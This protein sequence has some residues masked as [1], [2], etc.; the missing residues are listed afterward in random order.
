VG[1][2]ALLLGVRDYEDRAFHSL[3]AVAAD[4]DCLSQVLEEPD[5]GGFEITAERDPDAAAM[6]A[7]IAGFLD[8]RTPDDVVVL[9]LSGHG[10]WSAGIGQLY[11]AARDTRLDLLVQTGVPAEYLNSALEE[12]RAQQKAVLLDCCYSGAFAQGFRTRGAGNRT[13]LPPALKSAVESRGVYVITAC[14]QRQNAYEGFSG[15]GDVQPSLFTAAV[16]NGLQTGHADVMGNGSITPENL[17]TYVDEQFRAHSDVDQSPTKS[18]VGVVGS[19]M[20]LA[21][22]GHPL[23]LRPLAAPDG[24]DGWARTSTRPGDEIRPEAT[25]TRLDR[26]SWRRLLDYYRDCLGLEAAN[27]ELLPLGAAGR[28][29][30]ALWTGADEIMVGGRASVPVPR[31]TAAEALVRQAQSKGRTL[32][33]GYPSVLLFSRQGDRTGHLAPLFTRIVEPLRNGDGWHLQPVGVVM[34]H[35]RLIRQ[36]LAADDADAVLAEFEPGW[37]AGS[38]SQM[39]REATKRLRELDLPTEPLRPTEL[40]S[41]LDDQHPRSGGCN[42][43]LLYEAPESTAMAQGIVDGLRELREKTATFA[44]TGL[45]VFAADSRDSTPG[46]SKQASLRDAASGADPV[47]VAPLQLNEAQEAVLRSA[48]TRKLTVATGPPGTGKSQLVANLIATAVANDQSVLV[49]STNNRAVDEV[50]ERCQEI[51]PGLILRTGS[52]DYVQ[53]EIDCLRSL[54]ATR[55]SGARPDWDRLRLRHQDH[56]ETCNRCAHK[57]RTEAE[58]HELSL[59]RHAVAASLGFDLADLPDWLAQDSKVERQQRRA[60]AIAEATMFGDWQRRRLATR[61]D[62]SDATRE[63]CSR[64]A[65][66]LKIE[67]RWRRLRADADLLPSDLTLADELR[68]SQTEIRGA[69][70]ALVEA[71]VA[72]KVRR[73]QDGIAQRLQAVQGNGR[74]WGAFNRLMPHLR[75]WAV[76]THSTR[77]LPLDEA[78]FDLVIVD[79]ATQCSIP[80]VLPML[81]RAK[82]V[83]M[84]GDPMQLTHITTCTRAQSGAA[85]R[86]AGLG[87]AFLE[88]FQLDF[89]GHSAFDAAAAAFGEPLMLDEHFRCHPKIIAL[90]NRLF[91]GQRLTILTD[92]ARM[93]RAGHRARIGWVD[94]AGSPIRP[95]G[96][97]WYNHTEVEKVRE[98][99]ADLRDHLSPDATIGVVTPFSAQKARLG[100]ALDGVADRV[101]TAHAFQGGECDAM[102]LSLVGGPQMHKRSIAWLERNANLWN[103]AITR[104]RAHLVVVGDR[105]F[106]C[107]RS[108]VVGDLEG[109][110]AG[111]LEVLGPPNDEP[112]PT[113]DA[114]HRMLEQRF[115]AGLE[116]G[117]T[118][119]GYSCDFRIGVQGR[120]GCADS[121]AIILDRGPDGVDPARYLRLQF[122]RCERLRGIGASAVYRVPA[123]QVHAEPDQA[124]GALIG[125]AASSEHA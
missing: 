12:C 38:H 72:T 103:V 27:A 101:G 30:F 29:R 98:V 63:T 102:V 106:W 42:V 122:E 99:V 8:A 59:R 89:I 121:M 80:A 17:Y 28:Q 78:G 108:G 51:A 14:D 96:G 13:G 11:F 50:W 31:G 113:G 93:V 45:G 46:R 62:L 2:H 67:A 111:D 54:Q 15:Y 114:L 68:T 55:S 39:A 4:L 10:A 18:T 33:Y 25:P 83:L 5:I 118:L 81:Y 40:D 123:W 97:S 7:A 41:E 107:G 24:E 120:G 105:D 57:V 48:M 79:E 71:I 77:R 66:F 92:P 65:E 76:T 20:V 85:R 3:P 34:L 124:I 52:G 88:R 86:A 43:A 47:L 70:R 110:T 37:S 74:P 35:P 26:E 16:V 104:A 115:P 69:S 49:T 90:P 73:A 87:T 6:K 56:G 75:A 1:R 32:A 53:A 9:Y 94:V 44:R 21:K 84:I 58:L 119:A 23:R 19:E 36:R 100:E 64:A 125:G 95:A 109:E 61:L 117:A 91:Y 22:S 82:R 112:D 60:H 116:R